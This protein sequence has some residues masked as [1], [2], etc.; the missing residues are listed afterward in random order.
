M[1]AAIGSLL[2]LWLTLP[3]GQAGG[4][5]ASLAGV[6]QRQPASASCLHTFRGGGAGR[7]ERVGDARVAQVPCKE[8][9]DGTSTQHMDA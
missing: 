5:F 7:E 4:A 2:R 1:M 3:H 8:E 9:A 6:L